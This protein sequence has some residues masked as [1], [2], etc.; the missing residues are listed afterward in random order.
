MD[1]RDA[2]TQAGQALDDIQAALDRQAI[3]SIEAIRRPPIAAMVLAERIINAIRDANVT[4]VEAESAIGAAR[5]LIP[6]LGL[7]KGY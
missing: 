4:E 7:A 3:E 2:I 1:K 6:A 5:N